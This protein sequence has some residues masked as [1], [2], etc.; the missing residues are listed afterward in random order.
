[1]KS[2]GL[3]SPINDHLPEPQEDESSVSIDKFSRAVSLSPEQTSTMERTLLNTDKT[4][5][6]QEFFL[7]NLAFTTMYDREEEVSQAHHNT[8]DFIFKS[9]L[10]GYPS[11]KQQDH[12]FAS[13]LSAKSSSSVY[14]INGKAGSGKSTLMRYLCDNNQT[15][16]LLKEWAG[17]K[18]L[19]CAH[20][21]FWTSGN[22]D[23]RSQSGLLR[24]LLHQLLSQN[25]GLIPWAFH[26]MW[27]Y[28]QDT[29]N[30]IKT[31]I[32]WTMVE[33]RRALAVFLR[34][35]ID[36]SK[37]CL[38]IDGLDEL[39]GDQL[40]L[41]H[42]L[43]DI[44]ESSPANI[45]ACVSSRPW[46]VFEKSF[47]QIPQLKLQ[48]LN[49]Q[50]IQK[51]INDSLQNS[52]VA[53]QI[54]G[55]NMDESKKLRDCL[56]RNA[57]G[58]F[59]WAILAVRNL[60]GRIAPADSINDLALKLNELPTDLNNLFRHLL[61]E[62]RSKVELEEQARLLRIIQAR[63]IIC[64]STRD[65]SSKSMTIYQLALAD[66]DGDLNIPETIQRP[67]PEEV[68]HVYQTMKNHITNRCAGLLVLH[69]RDKLLGR[70]GGNS[71]HR[72]EQEARLLAL[73]R[74]GY[75]HRTIRDFLIF[76]DAREFL[77]KQT[78]PDFDP[79][80]CILRSIV[81]QYK[82][83]LEE[84]D[85]HRMLNDWWPD[86]VMAMTSS[87]LSTCGDPQQQCLLLDALEDT[88]DLYWKKKTSDTLD[89][90]ARAA[91]ATYEERMKRK[92]PYYHPFLSLATKFGL[93]D[94]VESKLQTERYTYLGGI[95]LLSYAVELLVN[96]RK[97]VY[98]PS[99]PEVVGMLLVNGQDP[100]LHYRDLR[101]KE[102]TPW[103][104]ALKCVREAD[105]RGWIRPFDIDESGVK[106]WVRILTLFVEHGADVNALILE[107]KWDPA[108]SALD[109]VEMVLEKYFSNDVNELRQKLCRY[110]ATLR[111]KK[112]DEGP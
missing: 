9:Q 23:Q 107:D 13:W 38:F 21:Y 5:M 109:V 82:L 52:M 34:R 48:D 10:G 30:R 87:R 50:D 59:L 102:E 36:T 56:V 74:V 51:Y 37:I 110:G 28:C 39:D 57:D 95:P 35:A 49:Q 27:L 84:V 65:Q 106:R 79:N 72:A 111:A 19:M 6:L 47:S 20:F 92:T 4:A 67:S 101:D 24:H 97:S 2:I 112:A 100:N 83:P 68:M 44:V 104:L 66:Q 17:D 105:R 26:D 32:E 46:P 15:Q 70:W 85:Q 29:K 3:N 14:W 53:K 76:S 88:L 73:S 42:M 99:T 12:N 64:D 31:V 77:V 89:S 11:D 71:T 22:L 60:L 91:F 98:P 58:V 86:I 94:Y 25:K 40:A 75:M 41:V 45:K 18:T 55:Q 80:I 16:R 63:E 90:W 61:F 62:S 7:D 81:L 33:L 96:R 1:M 54:L 43:K 93:A 108:A 69:S 8:F 103:L 78:Q